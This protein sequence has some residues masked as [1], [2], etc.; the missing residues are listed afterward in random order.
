MAV[1]E[2]TVQPSRASGARQP[3]FRGC[4]GPVLAQTDDLQRR[5]NLVSLPR[6]IRSGRYRPWC[7]RRQPDLTQGRTRYCDAASVKCIGP[8]QFPSYQAPG[9]LPLSSSKRP[10]CALPIGGLLM[11]RLQVPLT[12]VGSEE[13]GDSASSGG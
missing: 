5:V 13:I 2:K 1:G 10:A 11:K 12:T 7:W 4:S 9:G 3:S 8:N 6:D